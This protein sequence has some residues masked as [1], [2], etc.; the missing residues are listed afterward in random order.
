MLQESFVKQ[1]I[2][3]IFSTKLRKKPNKGIISVMEVILGL[4]M[5]SVCLQYADVIERLRIYD[6][7]LAMKTQVRLL[8][9]FLYKFIKFNL[10]LRLK[11]FFCFKTFFRTQL[12]T[13]GCLRPGARQLDQ[14]LIL[15]L[16]ELTKRYNQTK[17][18]YFYIF[19][20]LLIFIN[21]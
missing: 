3:Y 14:I 16:L 20:L 17:K 9:V 6:Q 11:A 5:I 21:N 19:R 10:N 15:N 13:V 1:I 2:G 18:L 4:S 7:I 8:T 12:A